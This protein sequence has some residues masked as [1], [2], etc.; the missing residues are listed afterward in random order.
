MKSIIKMAYLEEITIQEARSRHAN[1][2]SSVTNRTPTPTNRPAPPPTPRNDLT[3]LQDQIK[4]IQQEMYT[5]TA[6]TIPQIQVN[7]QSLA[8]DLED[9]NKKISKFDQR[10]SSIDKQQQINMQIQQN[11]FDRLEELLMGRVTDR[12]HSPPH[13]TADPLRATMNPKLL[14][15]TNEQSPMFSTTSQWPDDMDTENDK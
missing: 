15:H 13:A 14:H 10:F 5:M 2:Y 4:A 11:R 6:A 8:V 9:T 7:I 3:T 12:S 1:L